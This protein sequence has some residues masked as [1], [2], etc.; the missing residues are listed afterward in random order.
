M[1]TYP[2]IVAGS[3]W[4][5]DQ[6]VVDDLLDSVKTLVGEIVSGGARGVASL[7]ENWAKRNSIAIKRFPANWDLLGNAAGHERN[8]QMARYVS[9]QSGYLLLV[10]DGESKGSLNIK[11]NAIRFSI[12]IFEYLV[13]RSR[14]RPHR[15]F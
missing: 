10:W 6:H 5:E 14:I 1:K 3:R 12:P 7:G 8:V 11:T 13:P 2:V 15:P 9:S 4:I